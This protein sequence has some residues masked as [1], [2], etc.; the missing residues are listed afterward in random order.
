M[1]NINLSLGD[2]AVF[3]EDCQGAIEYY[4]R[5]IELLERT[6]AYG[7]GNL[8]TSQYG[9]YLFYKPS[10]ALDLLP[11]MENIIF[12]QEAIEGMYNLGTCYL[13]LGQAE[14]AKATYQEILN[15]RPGDTIATQKLAEI[16][17]E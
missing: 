13:E 17:G 3:K 8:G 7:I 16:R 5:A 2:L 12:S 11:G 1:T 6:T 15:Y 9:W 10:I 4:S 14:L